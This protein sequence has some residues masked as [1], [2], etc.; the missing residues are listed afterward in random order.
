MRERL[1]HLEENL[2]VLTKWQESVTIEQVRRDKQA[3]WAL[4]YGFFET[5][6]IIIDIACHIV[7]SRNLAKLR[8]KPR[9][10]RVKCRCSEEKFYGFLRDIF[11]VHFLLLVRKKM[12]ETS[13]CTGS[14]LS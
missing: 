1:S 9:R 3:E 10:K 2:R 7:S 6:Q 4:R 13:R 14:R 12:D 11:G 5:I 8:L